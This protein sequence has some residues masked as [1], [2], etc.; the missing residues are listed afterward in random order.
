MPLSLFQLAANRASVTI[1]YAGQVV[2]LDYAPALI[3]EKTIA[4][5][6]DVA[7]GAQALA[8]PGA[9]SAAGAGGLTTITTF[10]GALNTLLCRVV[11]SW[12]VYED[13][14]QTVMFPLTPERLAE[15]PV[16]FRAACFQAIFSGLRLG[17]TNGT[18]PK[19]RSRAST[20]TAT[21]GGSRR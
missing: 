4:E 7:T 9:D 5:V 11:L 6:S 18:P 2:T 20:S 13:E 8:E 3:T 14:A 16:D 12:D 21:S 15:L 19:A 17:E 10:M 1:E